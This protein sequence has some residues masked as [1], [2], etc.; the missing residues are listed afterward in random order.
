MIQIILFPATKLTKE[1]TARR[2]STGA[3]AMES[4]APQGEAFRS[5]ECAARRRHTRPAIARPDGVHPLPPRAWE[6][7]DDIVAGLLTQTTK[8]LGCIVTD[9]CLGRF[10]CGQVIQDDAHGIP[11][12]FALRHPP[13]G[14][15]PALLCQS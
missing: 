4:V 5:S 15:Q 10:R 2:P 8:Q 3:Q 1:K 12:P 6:R 7:V 13:D 9:P 11:L 14:A